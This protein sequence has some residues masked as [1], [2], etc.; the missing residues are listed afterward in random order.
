VRALRAY[1]AEEVGRT[2]VILPWVVEL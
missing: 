2:P 1:F